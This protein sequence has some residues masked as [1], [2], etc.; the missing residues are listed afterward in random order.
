[1]GRSLRLAGCLM[2]VAPS[3]LSAAGSDAAFKAMRK[4]RGLALKRTL[5]PERMTCDAR[6]PRDGP[7]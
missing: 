4:A 2:G 1:M 6:L 3:R 5:S 7:V